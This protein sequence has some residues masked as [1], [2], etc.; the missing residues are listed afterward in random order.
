MHRDG[1]RVLELE[2]SAD[3][4]SGDKLIRRETATHKLDNLTSDNVL[5]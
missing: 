5:H 1:W 3:G 4:E 2:G